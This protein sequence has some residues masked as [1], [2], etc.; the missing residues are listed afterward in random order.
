MRLLTTTKVVD[1][2]RLRTYDDRQ[3]G[4][5]RPRLVLVLE[6]PQRWGDAGLAG[7]IRGVFIG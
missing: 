6:R 5:R 3:H 4:K 7:L 1:K 2:S